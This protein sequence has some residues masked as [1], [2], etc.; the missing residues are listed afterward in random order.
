MEIAF[1]CGA[2]VRLRGEVS[3]EMLRQVIELLR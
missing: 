2:R 3:L 1:G